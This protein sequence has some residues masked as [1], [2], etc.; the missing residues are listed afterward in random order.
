MVNIRTAIPVA[1][2]VIPFSEFMPKPVEKGKHG[3]G[4]QATSGTTTTTTTKVTT[5]T[6]TTTK[7]AMPAVKTPA[8]APKK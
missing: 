3:K 6:T 5:T 7:S 2:T 1:D 4:S 8:A